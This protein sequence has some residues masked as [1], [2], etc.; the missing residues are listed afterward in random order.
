MHIEDEAAAGSNV[1]VFQKG[2]CLGE[3]IIRHATV[4]VA[5][6]LGGQFCRQYKFCYILFFN[7]LEGC[8]MGKIIGIDLAQQIAPWRFWRLASLL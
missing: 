6:S 8:I 7:I 1:E 2:Y 4:K 3:R 5:N